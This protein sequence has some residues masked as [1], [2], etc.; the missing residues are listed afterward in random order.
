VLTVEVDIF[1]LKNST[2]LFDDDI[3]HGVPTFEHFFDNLFFK[4]PKNTKSPAPLSN[5]NGYMAV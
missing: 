3:A 1:L 4:P 5:L 2:F